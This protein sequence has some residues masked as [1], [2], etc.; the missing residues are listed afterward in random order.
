[1]AHCACL[2]RRLK[3]AFMP[4]SYRASAIHGRDYRRSLLSVAVRR[5]DE[6]TTSGGAS[7]ALSP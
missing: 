7:A 3:G 6:A 5:R 4:Q 2:R 1:M